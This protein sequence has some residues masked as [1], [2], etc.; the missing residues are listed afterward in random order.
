MEGC[1]PPECCRNVVFAN[2][3]AGL[4]PRIL[5]KPFPKRLR[6]EGFR[7]IYFIRN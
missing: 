6:I 3:K 2:A 4:H 7:K 1:V 5:K